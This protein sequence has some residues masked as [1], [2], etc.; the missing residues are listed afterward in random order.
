MI[1]NTI[2]KVLNSTKEYVLYRENNDICLYDRKAKMVYYTPAYASG[3]EAR[4]PENPYD[5]N[6]YEGE[7]SARKLD[8]NN[9]IDRLF[10]EQIVNA[11]RTK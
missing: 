1:N 10:K 4:V 5:T 8:M 9:E 3:K 6:A 2:Y 7:V 11:K